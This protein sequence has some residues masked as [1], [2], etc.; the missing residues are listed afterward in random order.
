MDT[1]T[2]HSSWGQSPFTSKQIA[3]S[4]AKF[5]K[6][7]PILP[8]EHVFTKHDA[9]ETFSERDDFIFDHALGWVQSKVNKKSIGIRRLNLFPSSHTFSLK[10]DIYPDPDTTVMTEGGWTHFDNFEFDSKPP[11]FEPG[12][13][14]HGPLYLKAFD[15]IENQF[16][17]TD[18]NDFVTVTKTNAYKYIIRYKNSYSNGKYEIRTSYRRSI[19]KIE[20]TFYTTRTT[21]YSI[22]ENNN[23]VEFIHGLI[24]ELNSYIYPTPVKFNYKYDANK[25]S[26]M[27]SCDRDFEIK[28]TYEFTHENVIELVKSLNQPITYKIYND[29][30]TRSLIKLFNDNVWNRKQAFFHTS[31]SNCNRRYIGCNNDFWSSPT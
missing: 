6:S 13:H 24:N 10:F 23:I 18:F 9:K 2:E 20:E 7:V 15:P 19:D 27:L 31:F 29:L 12:I 3:S 26:L 25:G 21:T 17:I 5:N 4:A 22:T 1:S 14:Y 30:Q 28:E 11:L 8:V 16:E